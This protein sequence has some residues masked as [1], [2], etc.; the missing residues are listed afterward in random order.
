[1]NVNF[2]KYFAASGQ[3]PDRCYPR[4]LA[5]LATLTLGYLALSPLAMAEPVQQRD[6]QLEAIA[7]FY[8]EANARLA[9]LRSK[10]SAGDPEAQFV[11][12]A[13][14]YDKGLPGLEQDDAEALRWLRQSASAGYAE[15]MTALAVVHAQGRAV[16]HSESQSDEWLRKA[17]TRD[18]RAIFLRMY[19]QAGGRLTDA[20]FSRM[21]ALALPRD[22]A[23]ENQ[24]YGEQARA[25]NPEAA[26]QAAW[27]LGLGRGVER[28]E[29]AAIGALLASANDGSAQAA[30]D[31]M[32]VTRNKAAGMTTRELRILLSPSKEWITLPLQT[33]VRVLERG[34]NDSLV[35]IPSRRQAGLVPTDAIRIVS[36]ANQ[37]SSPWDPK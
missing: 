35:Y 11:L 4:V 27:N 23:F 37:A 13:G 20:P 21:G 3:V 5:S 24:W 32:L 14:Y 18:R 22:L 6:P 16:P 7:S 25:G 19:R 29:A 26:R 34:P 30:R 9:E 31:L 12:G 8:R 2:K 33:A 10:A 36:S 28:S 17:G 1:M 15:A